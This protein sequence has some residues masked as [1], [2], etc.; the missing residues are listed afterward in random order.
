[1]NTKDMSHANKI[2]TGWGKNDLFN[3]NKEMLSISQCGPTTWN[4]FIF[5][6]RQLGCT[7]EHK[8]L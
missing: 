5:H 8:F 7:V 3:R 1:M 4:K 6:S 2:L